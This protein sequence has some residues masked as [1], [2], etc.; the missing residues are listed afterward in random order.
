MAI[1]LPIISEWNPKGIDKAIADFKK[2][3]TNGQK[4]A[5][6]IKK[7]AVPA[8]LAIAALGAV[9]FDAVKAF[10]EDEAAAEKLGL[11][12]QNVTY[13]TDAQIASVEQFITK[14]SM[15]AAVADD[16]LRP[17]LDKLVRGTGDV[18]QAQDLLT[19]ALDVSSGTGKDLG[20]VADALSKAYN[21]NFTA[22]KKLD[23]ALASLIEEG[24]DADEVFGRLAGT[25]KNQ[26]STAANTTQGKMKN[27]SIQMGEFKESIGAAVAPLIEKLLPGLLR[28]S[29]WA[30][31]NT[32]LI[33]TLGLVIGGIATAII[34]TNAALAV[35]NTIQAATAALNTALTASFSALWV[36]TGAIIIIGIIAA[37]VALQVK[38]DIFG[39][40]VNAVQW[41]FT[42]MWGVVKTVFNWIKDNWQLLVA[43]ITGPFGLAVLAVVKFKDDIMNVFSIIYNGIKATMGFIAD[44]ITAPFKAAFKAVATLWN[45]TVGKLS[46][47]VPGWVPG[48]GGKG[49]DV[50]DIPMLENGGIVTKATLAMIGEGNEPEAVIPLSKLGSMGFGG[51]GASITVNVNG[52]DPNSIVR[53][54]QQYVRQSGPVPVNTRAM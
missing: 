24:A 34:A 50:P 33:V 35:Y 1:N 7:A 23:P 44:V 41:Y 42:T 53:A 52:G 19:L 36:A 15:A 9:A 25:F 11:T 3:E 20:A 43:V 48:I 30:Q 38:F 18:A 12:L 6:A 51:G 14:T 22:L 37:L 27:L 45:N 47:T 21:G 40:A 16:E 54:L 26:A 8:G 2:L 28:F 46:F 5:F 49:F 32:G 10:A 13:A 29:T 39:K 31:E 4:A 17:A